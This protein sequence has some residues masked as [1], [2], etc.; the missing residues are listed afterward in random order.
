[1]LWDEKNAQINK[2]PVEREGLRRAIFDEKKSQQESSS[3][4]AP[5]LGSSLLT[6]T[7]VGFTLA[8]VLVLV[9]VLHIPF[10]P[11]WIATTG[12]WP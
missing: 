7:G 12:A 11:W 4:V 8:A 3:L 1:L 5:L 10:G 2:L 6:G 9:Q